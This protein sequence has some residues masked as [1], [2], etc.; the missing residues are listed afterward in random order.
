MTLASAAAGFGRGAH[1]VGVGRYVTDL[2]AEP[3]EDGSKGGVL[4]V[5]HGDD[6]DEPCA[7]G[8]LALRE[9]EEMGNDGAAAAEQVHQIGVELNSPALVREVCSVAVRAG[10][11]PVGGGAFTGWAGGSLHI[12]VVRCGWRGARK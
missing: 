3:G 9:A 1:G 4:L 6:G 2:G 5:G 8:L 10:A 12:G 7:A 11:A